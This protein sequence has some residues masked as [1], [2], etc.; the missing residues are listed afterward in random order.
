MNFV[1]LGPPG[2]GKGSLAILAAKEYGIPHISTGDIFRQAVKNQTPLGLKVKSIMDSGAL[3]SDEVTSD[4]VKERLTALDAQKG[5]ILDGFP[6]TIEQ[7]KMFASFATD[8]KVVNFMIQSEQVVKR[9]ETRRVCKNCGANF[10][11]LTKP[12]KTEGIC[13]ECNGNLYQREDDK[14]ASIKKRLEVYLLQTQPLIDFY[15]EKGVLT[16]IDAGIESAKL[17]EIF[18]RLFPKG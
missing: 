15:S 10:N 9:L 17:L 7:A 8:I 12:P 14:A 5:Y 6:R 13:D 11:L 1:F 16:D 18:I 3:V 2:A 4:L